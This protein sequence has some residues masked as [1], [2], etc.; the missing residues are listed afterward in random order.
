MDTYKFLQSEYT[1]DKPNEQVEQK[2][3]VTH[4]DNRSHHSG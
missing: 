3:I 1:I 4:Y 2:A